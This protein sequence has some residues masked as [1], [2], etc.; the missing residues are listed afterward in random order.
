MFSWRRLNLTMSD[1]V[2]L[3]K[4]INKSIKLIDDEKIKERVAVAFIPNKSSKA[5]QS[6]LAITN[7]RLIFLVEEK[8]IAVNNE[9]IEYFTLIRTEKKFEFPVAIRLSLLEGKT[10][11]FVITHGSGGDFP[12]MISINFLE[13]VSNKYYCP[14]N[15]FN[16]ISILK[17][18]LPKKYK[19]TETF[20]RRAYW[21]LGL[22]A[23]GFLCGLIFFPGTRYYLVFFI[24]GLILG[25][26][27]NT[28][29]WRRKFKRK[30]L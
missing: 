25:Y 7:K 6:A 26:I 18:Y 4:I 3:H 12:E 29:Y 1:K 22:A 30:K 19:E 28:L 20:K 15:T 16:F 11:D 27:I 9:K 23:M 24:S 10:L 8:T 5:L 21:E 13:D 2:K 14:T 17:R